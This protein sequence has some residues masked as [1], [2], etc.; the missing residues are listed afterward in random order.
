VALTAAV[1]AGVAVFALNYSSYRSALDK[2]ARLAGQ[3]A[4]MQKRMTEL[5]TKLVDIKKK[6]NVS[7]LASAELQADF[8]NMA[9]RRRSF[10][11][12]VFLNRLEEVVPPG[13][14]V[15]DISPNFQTLDVDIA[16]K[17]RS[18]AHVTEFIQRLG[19]SGYFEDIP[20]VFHTSEVVVDKDTG[21]TAQ[22]F[23]LKIRYKPEGP[24]A[25]AK[26]AASGERKA[27]N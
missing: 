20:P 22:T 16:G 24:P 26:Q 12:T 6:V 14:G 9:I 7:E 1:L 8:A 17:A 4:L 23:S 2:G 27:A 11:W 18:V 5:D 15:T 21:E 3:A 25:K 13:V 10:S 19:A